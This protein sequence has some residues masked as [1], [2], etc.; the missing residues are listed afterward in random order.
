MEN[1]FK[2]YCPPDVGNILSPGLAA[3]LHSF[4]YEID[5][6][7]EAVAERLSDDDFLESI[8]FNGYT[9]VMGYEI[10]KLAALQYITTVEAM[11]Q[12]SQA[13]LE[14]FSHAVNNL[15]VQPSQNLVGLG[16]ELKQ[17]GK[18]KVVFSL[19]MTD[20]TVGEEKLT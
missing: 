8:V 19:F 4:K 11:S 9:F 6:I 12:I 1:R 3:E 14:V 16:L 13:L 18:P 2:N 5:A 10:N 15:T 17:Y 7:R 20:E